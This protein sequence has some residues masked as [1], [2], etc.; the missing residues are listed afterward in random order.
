M[1]LYFH[2]FEKPL[3]YTPGDNEWTDCNK[4]EAGSYNPQERL[5]TARKVFFKD[6]QSY[7]AR[8]DMSP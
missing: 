8:P 3:I 6:R 2:Q 1:D 5:E 7:Q 4:L